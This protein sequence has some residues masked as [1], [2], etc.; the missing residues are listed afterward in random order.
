MLWPIGADD[1]SQRNP[2]THLDNDDFHI[3]NKNQQ[4]KNKSW[5]KEKNLHESLK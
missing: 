2:P 4:N 1:K 3:E 5:K